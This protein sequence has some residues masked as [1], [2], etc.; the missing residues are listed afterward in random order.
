MLYEIYRA[1]Q[2][3]FDGVG[4]TL[5]A[6]N[7]KT[8]LGNNIVNEV[9]SLFDDSGEAAGFIGGVLGTNS[10]NAS[11]ANK[12][13]PSLAQL[14][15]SVEMF[16]NGWVYRGYFQDMMVTESAQS[17]CYEY[18]IK[19]VATQRRGYRTNYLPFHR[20]PNGPSEYNTPHSFSKGN[21]YSTQES[22]Q[23]FNNTK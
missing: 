14:A 4:L 8:D 17:F 7:A 3:A 9:G 11:L 10:P 21:E 5:D 23:L 6:N 12:N 16:Y 13:I 2:Y 19:F 18:Q 22:A 1:E 20:S 15:F